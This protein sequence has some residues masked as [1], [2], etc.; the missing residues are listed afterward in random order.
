MHT[1]ILPIHQYTSIYQYI[2]IHFPQ[3]HDSIQLDLDTRPQGIYLYSQCR[4]KIPAI[5]PAP[6]RVRSSVRH[7][8][9]SLRPV[10]VRALEEPSVSS[11]HW[12][13]RAQCWRETE[14]ERVVLI[15]FLQGTETG[16]RRSESATGGGG[17]RRQRRHHN[18]P[19]HHRRAASPTGSNSVPFT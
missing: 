19:V 1:T 12:E 7:A 11:R 5:V 2:S 8:P 14:R 10:I 17:P 18:H 13:K 15:V 3:K 16:S 9:W 4:S 6:N